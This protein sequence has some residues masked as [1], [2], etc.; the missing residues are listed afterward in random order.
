MSSRPRRTYLD[1]LQDI[2]DSAQSAQEFVQDMDET[3]P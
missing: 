3:E 2:L 1:Y